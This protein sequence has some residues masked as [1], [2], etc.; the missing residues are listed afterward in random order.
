MIRKVFRYEQSAETRGLRPVGPKVPL[1]AAATAACTGS[2]PLLEFVRRGDLR[3]VVPHIASG[4]AD[5]EVR[6][7]GDWG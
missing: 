3:G 1:A 2:S 6:V 5:D 7:W 4:G